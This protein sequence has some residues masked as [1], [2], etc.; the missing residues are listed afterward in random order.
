[1][2]FHVMVAAPLVAL[3]CYLVLL[4]LTVRRGLKRTPRY[5]FMLYLTAMAVWAFGAVLVRA[6]FPWG[7]TLQR[8]KVMHVGIY[9]FPATFYHFVV[10]FLQLKSQRR[11]IPLTYLCSSLSIIALWTIWS[12]IGSASLQP[13]GTLTYTIVL[14]LPQVIQLLSA[15][16]WVALAV[17]NLIRAHWRARDPLLRN[18]IT[19]LLLV[20]AL[21]L[22]GIYSN[23]SVTVGQYGFDHALNVISALLLGYVITH[24]RLLDIQVAMRKAAMAL[25]SAML[26]TAVFLLLAF[27]LYVVFHIPARSSYLLAAILVGTGIG[28][29]LVHRHLGDILREWEGRLFLGRR[30]QAYRALQDLTRRMAAIGDWNELKA[31]IEATVAQAL[32]ARVVNLVTLD[33]G[34]GNLEA[35][36]ADVPAQAVTRA[37]AKQLWPQLMD[38]ELLAVGE[39]FVPIK[40]MHGTHILVIGPSATRRRYLLED[41][42]VLSALAGPAAL[43]LEN[44]RL[45]AERREAQEA[46]VRQLKHEV[47][48]LSVLTDLVSKATDLDAVMDELL[49]Y[50]LKVTHCDCGAIWLLDE[51]AGELVLAASEGLPEGFQAQEP[52]APVAGSWAEWLKTSAALDAMQLSSSDPAYPLIHAAMLGQ[53]AKQFICTPL[54]SA[55][56]PLGVLLLASCTLGGTIKCDLDFV[57]AIGRLL[58]MALRNAQLMSQA[59]RQAEHLRHL[60]ET[61]LDITSRVH[62]SGLLEAIVRHSVRLSRAQGGALLR[63]DSERQELEFLSVYHSIREDRHLVGYRIKVDGSV[64]GQVVQTGQPV[65][66]DDCHAWPGQLPDLALPRVRAMLQVPLLWEGQVI[67]VLS[68]VDQL[69]RRFSEDDVRLLSLFASQAA[70]ALKIAEAHARAEELAMLEE[71]N[72]IAREIHDGLLQ[73]LAS[74]MYKADLC[75]DLLEED[76]EAAEEELEEISQALQACIRETRWLVGALRPGGIRARG[77]LSMLRQRLAE[78]EERTGLVLQL[79]CDGD[80]SGLSERL[81]LVLLRLVQEALNNVRKHAQAERVWI[82]LD[83]TSPQVVRLSVQDDGRGFDLAE[84]MRRAPSGGRFGL[85]SMRERVAGVGGS[86]RIETEPGRGTRIE[87]TLPRERKISRRREEGVDKR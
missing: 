66:V 55:E 37:E 75:L 53:G 67:G 72:R 49:C 17:V 24:Y 71:R 59:R 80:D 11:Y 13:D 58:G 21:T 32:E 10:S 36:P 34:G 56:A 76:T 5:A 28:I 48:T 77:F 82:H 74:I 50:A 1:M 20:I 18:R 46:L 7:S 26:V 61:L 62:A 81:S 14:G 63:L 85:F 12:T 35:L 60:Y 25:V 70:I 65:I 40:T 31:T 9:Y 47:D 19:Y 22:I 29:S 30:Y 3:L 68:V 41:L 43:A 57:A 45:Q 78:F 52:R 84:E 51:A 15:N 4:A 6:D 27:F 86:L 79:R 87:A 64:A 38:D 83:F 23:F 39:L 42:E 8:L 69:D 44:A 33:E 2:R 73:D 54:G 16:V